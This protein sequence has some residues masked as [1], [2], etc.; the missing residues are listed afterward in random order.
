MQLFD[1]LWKFVLFGCQAA[2]YCVVLFKGWITLQAF[3]CQVTEHGLCL[4]KKLCRNNN[5]RRK[6]NILNILHKFDIITLSALKHDTVDMARIKERKNK[7]LSMPYDELQD[8]QFYDQIKNLMPD[9]CLPIWNH[10][11]NIRF[12]DVTSIHSDLLNVWSR[13]QQYHRVC[14]LLSEECNGVLLVDLREDLN[15]ANI[16]TIQ[17]NIQN[18]FNRRISKKEILIDLQD[19][20]VATSEYPYSDLARA[21]LDENN[22]NENSN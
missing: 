21:L 9:E 18:N 12:N 6:R 16:I 11:A 3:C 15:V 5:Q 1:Y 2:N 13:N 4:L 17:R 19:N 22:E 7:E 10:L 20:Y 14:R 8:A